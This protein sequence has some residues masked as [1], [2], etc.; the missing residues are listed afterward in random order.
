MTFTTAVVATGIA[1][2]SVNYNIVITVFPFRLE[3]LKYHNVSS[4]VGWLLCIYSGGLVLATPF[5]AT[6][7]ERLGSRRGIMLAGLIFLIASQLL[8]MEA[9]TFWVMC[10]GRLCEGLSSAIVMTAGLALICDTTPQEQV[11]GQLGTAMVGLPFGSLI[12]PPIGGALYA[13]WGYRAPFIFSVL[14]TVFDVVGRLFVVEGQRQQDQSS[15]PLPVV[16]D[17]EKGIEDNKNTMSP[18]ATVVPAVDSMTPVIEANGTVQLSAFGVLS[19]F[20]TSSRIMS[21][22]VVVFFCSFT[23]SAVDVTIPLRMQ[24]VW[25]LNSTKVGLVYIAAIVPTLISN[26]LAGYLADKFGPEWIA[27]LFTICGIPWFGAL[28]CHF[29]LAFFIVSYAIENF[30]IA[31]VAS[32]ITSEMAAVTR[33]IPGIGY[34][35]TYGSFNIL[36]GLGQLVGSIVGGQVYAHSQNGWDILCYIYIGVCSLCLVN[37]LLFTGE[38][39][40]LQRLWRIQRGGRDNPAEAS[41]CAADAA[42]HA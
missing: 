26:P 18:E 28:T 37:M 24:A 30:F 19:S 39:S 31:A 41:L 2:D 25:G 15:N 3:E 1:I 29:S 16:Q 42:A 22:L 12:G 11:G 13:R 4:L 5:I 23:F 6:I 7:S 8:L 10:L 27:I 36:L 40:I 38:R 14:L 17:N 21:A 33:N 20:L 32:P 34:A 9:P 35:H